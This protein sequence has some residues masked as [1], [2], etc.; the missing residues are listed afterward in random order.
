MWEKQRKSIGMIPAN[1]L[2]ERV[3]G[4]SN[5]WTS[6][7]KPVSSKPFNVTITVAIIKEIIRRKNK[8]K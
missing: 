4:T 3:I 5:S 6:F 1:D 8:M 2:N 7:I